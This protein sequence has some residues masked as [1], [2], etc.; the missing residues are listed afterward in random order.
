MPVLF[1]LLVMLMCSLSDMYA[2]AGAEV[3]FLPVALQPAAAA[4]A[5]AAAAAA[6]THLAPETWHSHSHEAGDMC[7]KSRGVHAAHVR[8]CF[9]EACNTYNNCSRLH[10]L[11]SLGNLDPCNTYRGTMH[12]AHISLCFRPQ[13]IHNNCILLVLHTQQLLP[14]NSTRMSA[15]LQKP[16]LA[17]PAAGHEGAQ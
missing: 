1:G 5:V 16:Q 3:L 15:Q 12:A 13:Y 14:P 11:D 7:S 2:C 10:G 17:S 9:P 4:A 6:P 8:L